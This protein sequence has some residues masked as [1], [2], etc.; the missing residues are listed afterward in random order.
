MLNYSN[1]MHLPLLNLGL[2]TDIGSN[3]GLAGNTS[4]N[5]AD[6]N[7][8]RSGVDSTDSDGTFGANATKQTGP[9]DEG[10]FP[11]QFRFLIGEKNK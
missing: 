2:V 4:Q 11:K 8:E 9:I 10:I 7:A 6:T 3:A 1:L 5:T